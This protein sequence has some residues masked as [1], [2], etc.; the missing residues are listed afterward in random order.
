MVQPA[1][2]AGGVF[3]LILL[4]GVVWG[5]FFSKPKFWGLFSKE[6]DECTP[7]DDDTIEKAEKEQLDKDKKCILVK[8][9]ATGYKPNSS[10]TACVSTKKKAGGGGTP[11]AGGGGTPPPPPPPGASETIDV[12][13]GNKGIPDPEPV[14]MSDL[15]EDPNALQYAKI[16]DKWGASKCTGGNVP[17]TPLDTAD[18]RRK[19]CVNVNDETLCKTKV[20]FALKMVPGVFGTCAPL[21]CISGYV[22]YDGKCAKKTPDNRRLLVKPESKFYNDKIDGQPG[23]AMIPIDEVQPD[24]T[25]RQMCANTGVSKSG[26]SFKSLLPSKWAGSH[27]YS[28]EPTARFWNHSINE[29]ATNPDLWDQATLDA[30]IEFLGKGVTTKGDGNVAADVT[31]PEQHG[32]NVPKG[33]PTQIYASKVL[34]G[35]KPD[36]DQRDSFS[37]AD[38]NNWKAFL[39]A[40][41]NCYCQGTSKPEYAW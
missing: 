29:I 33:F 10:N 31:N 41:A 34:L 22:P 16:G 8:T 7:K 12:P 40:K 26:K 28:A 18:P 2:V 38:I 23:V 4:V 32:D 13:F 3:V 39:M 6:G 14:W 11:S 25:C 21:E 1:A 5:Y 9:C 37:E 35:L 24:Y 20:D 15:M 30:F 27:I 19:Y 17:F 36:D